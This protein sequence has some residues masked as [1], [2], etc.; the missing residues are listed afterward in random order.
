[1][2]SA[3]TEERI[4]NKVSNFVE[5]NFFNRYYLLR[6]QL[7]QRPCFCVQVL[8]VQMMAHW[9]KTKFDWNAGVDDFATFS[10]TFATFVTLRLFF[11]LIDHF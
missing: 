1:M 5:K 2:K 3:N 9:P 6:Q 11:C 7:E 4:P 8:F 10:A